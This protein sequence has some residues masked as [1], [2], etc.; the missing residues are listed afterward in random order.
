M[1]AEYSKLCIMICIQLVDTISV[2]TSIGII[3]ISAPPPP[4]LLVGRVG[5]GTNPKVIELNSSMQLE[6]PIMT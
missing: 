2:Y 5:Y 3:S 4:P 1:N 6:K